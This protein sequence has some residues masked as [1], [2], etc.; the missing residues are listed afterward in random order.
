MSKETLKKE[1]WDKLVEV[2]EKEFPKGERCKC[3][4]KLPC[5]SKALVLNSYAYIYLEDALERIETNSWANEAVK[6]IKEWNENQ[7]MK[8]AFELISFLASCDAVEEMKNGKPNKDPLVKLLMDIY[9]IAHSFSSCKHPDWEE[10]WLN[11][12]E[13]LKKEKII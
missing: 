6:E 12:W 13:T 7:E 5:R 11:S 4:K 3:D 2:L 1:F 8:K 9:K 10:E